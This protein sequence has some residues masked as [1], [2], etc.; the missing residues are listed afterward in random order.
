MPKIE[1]TIEVQVPV[2]Q[3]YNQWTQFEDFPK[4]MN[5]IQSVQQ[6][7]DTHLQWVAEIRGESRQWTTEITEQQPDEKVAWKTIEGEVKNDGVVTF[8]P[9]GDAQTRVNVQMDVEGDST[10]E[11]VAGDL[12][13][14]VKKQVHGDLERFKQLIENRDEESG[15]W[16]GEVEESKTK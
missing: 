8:E 4:F 16:R 14:V 15:A 10:A 1:D 9:M 5:G 7:D 6:L 12:L 3:A 11:N 13:G 2:Q